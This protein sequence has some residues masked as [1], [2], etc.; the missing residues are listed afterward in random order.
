VVGGRN[1]GTGRQLSLNN[2]EKSTSRAKIM[3]LGI[4]IIG[5]GV[6]GAGHARILARGVA[7]GHLVGI[8]D[9]D[10]RRAE[11][12]A[13][14]CGAA[15]VFRDA[16]GLIKD[17]AIDAVVIVSPDD[18]H[19][20]LIKACL[21]VGK[22]VLCEKPLAANLD[23]CRSV[24]DSEIAVGRRL[25]QVGY[26][27]RFDPGYIAMQQ[28]LSSGGLGLPVLLRFIH[29]NATAPHFMT[30]ELV[31]TN[32]AVH[33][34]DIARYLLG[35]EIAG[36]TVI[37]S[38]PSQVAPE[39]QPHLLVLETES[40]VIIDAELFLDAQYGYDVQA[41]VVCENGTVALSPLPPISHKFAK[42][43]G[44]RLETDWRVRFADAYKNQMQAWIVSIMT[45]KPTGANAWDGYIASL[46]AMACLEA[47]QKRQRLSLKLPEKPPF[48]E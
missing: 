8:C 43:E 21:A 29:R 38:R 32:A 12:L 47:L 46:T 26:M 17:A 25:I 7:G 9:F 34:I 24:L 14:D 30:S 2:S 33:E 41:E 10:E 13:N 3:S 36:I 20:D 31:F 28:E 11:A 4:G 48:Y 18:T 42:Q 39:R 44:Y 27:R 5:A 23:E 16:R 6:M 19:A 37:S 15:R 40:G 35:E 1:F 45:G 22:P